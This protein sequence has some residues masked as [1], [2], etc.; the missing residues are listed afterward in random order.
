M[1]SK[2]SLLFFYLLSLCFELKAQTSESNNSLTL[3]NAIDSIGQLMYRYYGNEKFDSAIIYAKEKDSLT[4]IR[5]DT[6]KEYAESTNDV[7][8][9]YS[10]RILIIRMQ[11]NILKKLFYT[12]KIYPNDADYATFTNN[13]AHYVM[14]LGLYFSTDTLCR[15]SVFIRKAIFRDTMMHIQ[16]AL[17]I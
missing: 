16:K 6:S 17:I 13:M 5:Y 10:H 3:E 4:L 9:I 1:I 7:G 2:F 14:I 15:K 12:R 11:K 8:V